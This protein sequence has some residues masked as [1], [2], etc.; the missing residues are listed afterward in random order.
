MGSHPINLAIRFILELAALLATG[1]WG[2]KRYGDGWLRFILA[3]GIPI[4]LAV[5]WGTF[6][7][8]DD[9]SRSGQ[10]PVVTPGIIRLI[11]ELAFFGFAGWA[12]YD[13]GYIKT[14]LAMGIIVIL[15]YIVSYDRIIWLLSQ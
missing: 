15:H 10:A 11:I 2:W 4:V 8:P 9:P 13:V 7:V 1:M 14:S 3:F 6:A 12:L 5:I